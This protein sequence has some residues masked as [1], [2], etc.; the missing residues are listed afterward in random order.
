L[1]LPAAADAMMMPPRKVGGH[2]HDDGDTE[3]TTTA[4]ITASA[5]RRRSG[6]RQF[7]SQHANAGRPGLNSATNTQRAKPITLPTTP[8]RDDGKP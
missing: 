7:L 4:A 2:R 8:W 6:A 3:A 5:R 1:G